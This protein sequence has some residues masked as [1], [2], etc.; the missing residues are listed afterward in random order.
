VLVK[1][2]MLLGQT[3][4][5]ALFY[6]KGDHVLPLTLHDTAPFPVGRRGEIP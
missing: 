3:F 5:A 2:P 4:F 6:E 1:T